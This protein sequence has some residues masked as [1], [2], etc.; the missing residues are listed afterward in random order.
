V[1]TPLAWAPDPDDPEEQAFLALYGAW[2]PLTPAGIAELLQGFDAPWWSVG[3]Y[4]IEAFTGVPRFHEDVDLVMFTDAV[5]A[6]REHL[7]GVLHLWN[8]YD[9]TMRPL[10]EHTDTLLHPQSQIWM[11]RDWSSPWLVDCI[12]DLRDEQGRWVSKRDP[13]HVAPLEEVTWV[14]GDG[15]RYLRP[16]IQLFFKAKQDREKDRVDLANAWPLLDAAQQG[17][18]RQALARNLPEHPWRERLGA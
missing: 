17:W 2:D 8:I 11:R 4:A 14:A 1:S 5:P 10:D 6:L 7:D 16:E 3:G 13:E 18:L 12:L 15:I 9:R